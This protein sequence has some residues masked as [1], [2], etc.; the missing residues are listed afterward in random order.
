MYNK[1]NNKTKTKMQAGIMRIAAVLVLIGIVSPVDTSVVKV[2]PDS[3]TVLAG[4][5]FSVNITIEDVT[6]M[7]AAQARLFFDPS[8]MNATGGIEGEFLKSGG[9][10]LGSP[11]INNTEGFAGF[12]YMLLP[13]GAPVTGSG[14]LATINFN[15]SEEAEGTFNLNLTEIIINTTAGEIPVDAYNGTVK[16]LTPTPTPTV[17]FDTGSGTY[18]SIS[19]THNGTIKPNQTITVHKMYTY[20]CAGTGGHSKYVRIQSN[21]SW[22]IAEENWTGYKGDWHNLSFNP[23]FTLESGLTYNYTIKTGSY[24]QIIHAQNRT[25]LNG[26]LITCEEFTDANGKRYDDWILAIK[27]FTIK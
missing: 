14:V 7:D 3:Q 17:V 18:P 13:G 21:E 15:T 19:G 12:V 23:P 25:T 24:P 4:E 6:N 8:A 27:F 1:Y 11:I 16:I 10:T 2:V 22:I 9:S 5:N 20:P 26:S